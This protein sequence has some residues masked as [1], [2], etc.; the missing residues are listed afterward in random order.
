MTNPGES[1]LSEIN[2]K[3]DGPEAEVSD[4]STKRVNSLW[5]VGARVSPGGMENTV[6][7]AVSIGS[8]V[9]VI[10]LLTSL[11]GQTLSNSFSKRFS[12]GNRLL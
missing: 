9:P 12:F 7:N 1:A 3:S 6:I 11:L 8:A 4:D 2:A 10:K 5:K